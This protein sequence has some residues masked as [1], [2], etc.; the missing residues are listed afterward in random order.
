MRSAP[1]ISRRGGP[2]RVAFTFFFRDQQVLEQLVEH[3]LDSLAGRS[4]PRIWDAGVATGQEPYT[5]AIMFAERMGHF[6]C[7]NPRIDATDIEATGRFAGAVE[8][9]LY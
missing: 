7:N 6:A 2:V 1:W 5:L 8:A 3:S 9:G 4:H